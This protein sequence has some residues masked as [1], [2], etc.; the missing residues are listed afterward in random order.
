MIATLIFL[1]GLGLVMLPQAMKGF[2]RR[3][4][5]GMVIGGTVLLVIGFILS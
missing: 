3:I 1:A 5:K 2:P 4:E